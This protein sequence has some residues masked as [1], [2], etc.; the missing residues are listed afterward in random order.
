MAPDVLYAAGELPAQDLAYPRL[1]VGVAEVRYPVGPDGDAL[2]Q[3]ARHIGPRLAHGQRRIEVDVRFDERRSHQAS[4]Q[5][6]GLGG[7]RVV[8]DGDDDAVGDTE[9]GWRVLP[10]QLRI[11]ED[12]VDHL[13][14]FAQP[15]AAGIADSSDSLL[16]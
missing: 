1:D 7:G 6:D 11:A 4:A 15:G 10:G 9:I 8:T 13:A 5:V 14:I 3:R 16:G 12:E 2:E